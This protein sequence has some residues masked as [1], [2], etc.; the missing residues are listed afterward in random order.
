MKSLICHYWQILC[1]N[2]LARD[3]AEIFSALLTFFLFIY[4]EVIIYFADKLVKW[5]MGA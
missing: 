4:F 1:N 5:I 3:L 2:Q